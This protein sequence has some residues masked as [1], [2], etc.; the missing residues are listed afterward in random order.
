MNNVAMMNEVNMVQG[1]YNMNNYNVMNGGNT[2]N[3]YQMMNGGYNMNGYYGC[4]PQ[5][6]TELVTYLENCRNAI[7]QVEEFKPEYDEVAKGYELAKLSD[8]LCEDK[9][10]YMLYA[11][12]AV[13]FIGL[14]FFSSVGIGSSFLVAAGAAVIT[15]FAKKKFMNG[16]ME[17]KAAKFKEEQYKYQTVEN[18]MQMMRSNIDTV[19]GYI[20]DKYFDST[21]FDIMIDYAKTGRVYDLNSAYMYADLE[22]ERRHSDEMKREMMEREEKAIKKHTLATTVA[23]GAVGA[24]SITGCMIGAASRD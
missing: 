15:Y 14:E 9:W 2:M 16:D 22:L 17:K 12:P 11:I 10:N 18:Q 1:G 5:V 4:V 19:Y 7:K 6:N 8:E 13:T 20:P 21:L 24:L 3:G 23:M